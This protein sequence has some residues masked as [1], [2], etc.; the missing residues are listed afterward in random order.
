MSGTRRSRRDQWVFL[1]AAAVSCVLSQAA[2]AQL[3][4]DM[5]GGSP[6]GPNLG[7]DGTTNQPVNGVT[8]QPW[9]GATTLGGDGTTLPFTGTASQGISKTFTT[10]IATS[11]AVTVSLTNGAN[12]ANGSTFNSR[13]RGSPTGTTNNNDMYRD[14]LFLTRDTG[15]GIGGSPIVISLSGLNK[16][17]TYRFTGYANDTFN[18]G[19]YVFGE[20]NPRTYDYQP[21]SEQDENNGLFAN[22][23]APVDGSLIGP[24]VT[25]GSGLL[26][27][28]SAD[29]FG[30]SFQIT[31]DNTG[32]ATIYEWSNIGFTANQGAAV[33]NG[34]KIANVTASNWAGSAATCG[35]GIQRHRSRCGSRGCEFRVDRFSTDCHRRRLGSNRRCAEYR[36]PERLSFQWRHDHDERLVRR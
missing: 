19:Q 25:S 33:F 29:E 35:R 6:A 4:V 1:A 11:G 24:R 18:L 8:W 32:T 10:G 20:V 5:N 23:P 34:F 13:D 16:N 26:P 27:V 3:A 36:Q 28:T 15:T 7:W 9:G 14:F 21:A 2:S 30:S 17:T 31:T 22:P 12:G